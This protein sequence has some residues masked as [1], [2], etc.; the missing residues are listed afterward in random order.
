MCENGCDTVQGNV[1][2]AILSQYGPGAQCHYE[3]GDKKNNMDLVI[4]TSLVSFGPRGRRSA[5]AGTGQ[6][7]RVPKWLSAEFVLRATRLQT[8]NLLKSRQL[9]KRWNSLEKESPV[10]SCDRS[11][12]FKAHKS[13]AEV[14]LMEAKIQLSF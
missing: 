1:L 9:V 5:A 12:R 3:D 10:S 2:P 4:T 14:T 6:P 13:E 7:R 11:Q 8:E